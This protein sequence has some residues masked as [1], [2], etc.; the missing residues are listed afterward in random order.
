M[1]MGLN[2]NVIGC[3]DSN[4]FPIVNPTNLTFTSFTGPANIHGIQ[5]SQ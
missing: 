5:F 1:E 3:V 4:G 2:F